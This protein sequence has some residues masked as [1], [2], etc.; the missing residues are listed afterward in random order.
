MEDFSTLM[1]HEMDE[2]Q[3]AA[4]E[5]AWIIGWAKDLQVE[6]EMSAEEAE[7]Q[8]PYDY[9]TYLNQE[10][11]MKRDMHIELNRNRG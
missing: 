6:C 5:A 1:F 3:H 7:E 10:G 4:F 11:Y 9:E 2:D 8:A